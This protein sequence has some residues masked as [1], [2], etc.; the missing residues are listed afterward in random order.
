M[1]PINELWRQFIVSRRPVPT[2]EKWKVD[3]LLGWHLQYHPELSFCP[4]DSSDGN[5]IGWLIGFPTCEGTVVRN[6]FQLDRLSD[7]YQLGGP[8]NAFLLDRGQVYIDSFGHAPLVYSEEAQVVTTNPELVPGASINEPLVA[9]MNV[10]ADNNWFPFGLT[11]R[12]GV[13]RVLPNHYL[14]LHAWQAKR[15]WPGNNTCRKPISVEGAAHVVARVIKQNVEAVRPYFR[16]LLPLT[17]G[18]D[19]RMILACLREQV[20]QIQCFTHDSHPVTGLLD[21][22]LASEIARR[23]DLNH[24]AF[25]SQP[26]TEKEKQI[27]LER[28]GRSLAGGE[29]LP[30]FQNQ[31]ANLTKLA[32]VGGGLLKGSRYRHH[33]N[34]P[35]LRYDRLKSHPSAQDLLEELK[36]PYNQ[37]VLCAA[38]RWL[39]GLSDQEPATIWDLLSNEQRIGCWHGPIPFGDRHVILWPL[40]HRDVLDV[41]LRLGPEEKI[42]RTV[43]QRVIENEWPDLLD[44]PVNQWWG[45]R[46]VRYVWRELRRGN[47]E[48]LLYRLRGNIALRTRV[49]SWHRKDDPL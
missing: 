2:A 7:L 37:T 20:D 13:S 39:E 34:P 48:R 3:R 35:L 14:D 4:I 1:K 49:R 23:H 47:L 19:S 40:A 21:F 28:T 30:S 41:V 8:W 42:R 26:A 38:N 6:R 12:K 46:R 18:S 27:W 24:T 22:E 5:S 43:H 45:W 31:N 17:A 32:G 16:L 11:P 10:P 33:A 36:L 9:L 15:H 25:Q 44:L 29:R